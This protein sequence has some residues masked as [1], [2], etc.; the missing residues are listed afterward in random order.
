MSDSL[1]HTPGD[2]PAKNADPHWVLREEPSAPA[3]PETAGADPHDS[4]AIEGG[5]A[6]DV[7]SAPGPI[8]PPTP[9]PAP[10]KPKPPRPTPTEAKARAEATVDEVWSRWGEWGQ[11]LI[12]MG[13]AAL[14]TFLL[15]YLSASAQFYGLAFFFFVAGGAALAVL[16]YPIVI[17]LERPVRVT[18]EQAVNDFYAALSHH[19]PHYRRM[20]LLLSSAGRS[21]GPFS[22]YE[23]FRAYWKERLAS[24]HGKADARINP[25]AFSIHDFRSEKSGGL[26]N[27]D[28]TFDLHAT[29]R[30]GGEK[31][32]SVYHA[33][34]SLVRGP[35]R[36]WYLNSGTLPDERRAL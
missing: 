23:G 9:P 11:T 22:S 10:R 29:V 31:P 28:V 15:I 4:Y 1:P 12:P 24:L 30:D 6:L 5:D 18:P 20:W 2:E 35:D 13:G 17:T 21:S 26:S 36:M 25:L 3:P 16:S 14:L 8:V 27:I 34:M 33:A 19:L 7:S 32:I